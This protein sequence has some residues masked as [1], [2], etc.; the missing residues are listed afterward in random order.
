MRTVPAPDWYR[1]DCRPFINIAKIEAVLLTGICMI[2]RR[3]FL[4]A[5]IGALSA[6]RI[7]GYERAHTIPAGTPPPNP[8]VQKSGYYA[9]F[10]SS[11]G[12]VQT[13]PTISIDPGRFGRGVNALRMTS[14]SG[15]HARA[16]CALGPPPTKLL[17]VDVCVEDPAA[18]ARFEVVFTHN[19]FNGYISKTSLNPKLRCGLESPAVLH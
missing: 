15:V 16:E 9:K 2:G 12:W 8:L 17:Q 1:Q 19:S 13:G 10:I 4:A 14:V 5:G 18:V 6:P 3:K 7:I 11:E